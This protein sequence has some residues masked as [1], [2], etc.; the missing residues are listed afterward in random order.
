[1]VR[2]RSSRAP[3]T[4]NH[5]C[6]GTIYTSSDDMYLGGFLFLRFLRP[7][8]AWVDDH[9]DLDDLSLMTSL[10]L[11]APEGFVPS[12]YTTELTYWHPHFQ[13]LLCTLVAPW[14]MAFYCPSSF[15]RA[16]CP[17]ISFDTGKTVLTHIVTF[18][19]FSCIWIPAR[20]RIL[21]FPLFL[22]Y[23]LLHGVPPV[24]RACLSVSPDPSF[25]FG[26]KVPS[27]VA[28]LLQS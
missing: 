17:G 20:S 19:L 26:L 11:W 14:C 3:N 7:S 15:A 24:E 4:H 22:L 5:Y 6:N 16:S 12:A 28:F 18:G 13:G 1:M 9:Y 10:L 2:V 27:S 23:L 8:V 21:L 25:R